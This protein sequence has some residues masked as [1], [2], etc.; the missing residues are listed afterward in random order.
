MSVNFSFNGPVPQLQHTAD[1][2]PALLDLDV[3]L[4]QGIQTTTA[5]DYRLSSETAT[6]ERLIWAAVLTQTSE[7]DWDPGFGSLRKLKRLRPTD[8][9]AEQQR[10]L[11]IVKAIPYVTDCGVQLLWQAGEMIVVFDVNTD[12]GRFYTKRAVSDVP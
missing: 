7:L 9:R 3:P 6:V 1:L 11:A 10:L 2:V 5:G 12:F 4:R 8:L